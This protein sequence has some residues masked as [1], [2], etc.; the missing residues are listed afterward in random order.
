MSNAEQDQNIVRRPLKTRSAAWAHWLAKTLARMGFTPNQISILS[1]FFAAA[2]GACL[3]FS[4]EVQLSSQIALYILAAVCIQFRLLCNLLDGMIAVEGGLKTKSGEIY[5]DVP[6]R[7][8]D[9]MILIPAGYAISTIA[10]APTLAWLVGLLAVMT[11]YIRVLGGATGVTQ[12]FLG[13]MAKPHRM[14]AM[15]FTL[16][17]AAAFAKSG[18]DA[19]IIATSLILIAL[20]CL[21]TICRRLTRIVNELEAK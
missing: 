4:P 7:F 5:N 18:W 13:P 8:A 11:A 17:L 6:D 16:L 12:H 1:V 2:S 19:P 10:W 21:I 14:A 15:T 20:G 9:C 3:L